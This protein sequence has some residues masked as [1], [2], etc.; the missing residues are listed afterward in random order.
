M[1]LLFCFRW[2]RIVV[3]AFTPVPLPTAQVLIVDD[4]A[5]ELYLLTEMLRG[6]DL[7]LNGANGVDQAYELA[8]RNRPDLIVLG[9]GG[10]LDVFELERLLRSNPFTEDIPLLAITT[11]KHLIQ[12]LVEARS[13]TLDYL[14]KPFTVAQLNQ[15]VHAQ[16]KLSSLLR[17]GRSVWRDDAQPR[18]DENWT[19]V[20][21]TKKYLETRLADSARL[22]DIAQ[23]LDVPERTLALAFQACLNMSVPEYVRHERMR[24]AKQLLLHTTMSVRSIARQ[25]GFSSAANFS[26]AFNGWVGTTPSSFRSQALNNALIVNRVLKH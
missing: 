1:R 6:H 13:I 12:R 10:R 2:I 22:A 25:V 26:T 21:R 20:R 14:V 11:A 7:R 4:S 17:E 9:A 5:E 23:A 19:L 8:L 15:R 16:L 3:N 18:D 24:R